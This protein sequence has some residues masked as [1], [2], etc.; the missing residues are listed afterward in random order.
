MMTEP[1]RLLL[2]SDDGCDAAALLD[3]VA[4]LITEIEQAKKERSADEMRAARNHLAALHGVARLRR[5]S[6]TNPHAA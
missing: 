1:D 5:Q 4:G 6:E 2:L 3:R